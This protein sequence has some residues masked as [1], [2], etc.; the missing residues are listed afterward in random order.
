MLKQLECINDPDA[1]VVFIRN[2]RPQLIA[3]GALV[4]ESKSIYMPFSP[5]FRSDIL[6]YT[7]PSGCKISFKTLNAAADLPGYDGTQFTRV[8]FDE[9]QNQYG[10][11]AVIYLLSRLRSK[12]KLHH[13][14]VFT[15]N[16][17]D[18]WLKSWV[19]YCLDEDGVP[20]P[21]T[22]YKVR[23]F[24]RI[25]N[26]MHWADSKKELLTQFPDS[27][28]L[29]FKFIPATCEDNPVLLANNPGYLANLKSLKKIDQL[30]LWKG[31]WTARE[32]ASG[33][34]NRDSVHIA[35][36]APEDLQRVRAWDFASSP[37]PG[38]H[39]STGG[40][41]DYS[42]GVLMGRTKGGHY[43]VLDVARFRKRT[44]EVLEEIVRIA[45]LD[46]T[47]DTRVVITKD[48][49]AAGAHFAGFL[50]RTLVEHGITPKVLT[51]SGHKS[52]MSRFLPFTAL[53]D[54]GNVSVLAAPWNEKWFNEL[55]S[56]TGGARNLKDD[57]VDA[58]ADAA[59]VL[60]VNN[61]LPSFSL[62]DM[63]R[64]SVVPS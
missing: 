34:F 39:D 14:I 16:P 61:T 52:K 48:P 2:T 54:S 20:K 62:P 49:G 40:N 27:L 55:E 43:Y 21:G 10:E 8:I 19:D 5:K 4:D 17:R 59:T 47:E 30:R 12:S 53:C 37:E 35:H 50:T 36:Q 24:V 23:W 25:N 9:V 56:F 3:S 31:S 57:Q 15:A 1:R 41:P 26:K 64:N 45:K 44:N 29:S 7:F 6:E 32:D 38:E 42:V 60:M 18:C 11:E 46:G 33:P 63:S 58:T 51:A 22:E 28:P 13:Q